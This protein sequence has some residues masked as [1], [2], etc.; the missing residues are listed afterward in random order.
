MHGHKCKCSTGNSKVD[1]QIQK[2]SKHETF[3]LFERYNWLKAIITRCDTIHIVDLYGVEREG[4][5]QILGNGIA[6]FTPP[7]QQLLYTNAS[8]YE[9]WKKYWCGISYFMS[10]MRF[11]I[12]FLPS[13]PYPIIKDQCQ[14]HQYKKDLFLGPSNKLHEFYCKQIYKLMQQMIEAEKYGYFHE[15]I[16]YGKEAYNK[17][18][19]LQNGKDMIFNKVKCLLIISRNQLRINC[20]YKSIRSIRKGLS[21]YQP[22]WHTFA[23]AQVISQIQIKLND[24]HLK[25]DITANVMRYS[26]SKF[27]FEYDGYKLLKLQKNETLTQKLYR[28]RLKPCIYCGKLRDKRKKCTRCWERDSISVYYCNKKCQKKHWKI[29][30]Q[31]CKI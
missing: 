10:K 19:D 9:Y 7:H 21:Y 29:H 20:L 14:H 24:V 5:L 11:V 17:S 23:F 18:K 15:S 8:T 3:V 27:N 16:F 31:I 12:G 2:R 26:N 28:L 25:Y 30:R 4:Y 22:R 1:K 6:I 13:F